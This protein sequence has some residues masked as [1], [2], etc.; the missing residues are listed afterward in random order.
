MDVPE[1]TIEFNRTWIEEL[2]TLEKAL[3]VYHKDKFLAVKKELLGP[4]FD[5]E[6]QTKIWQ[7]Y[8][9]LFAKAVLGKFEKGDIERLER[10]RRL[11][12]HSETLYSLTGGEKFHFP[13]NL[14]RNNAGQI[15]R[16]TFDFFDNEITKRWFN[17][18]YDIL[19]GREDV[20]VCSDESCSN[21]FIRKRR[22]DKK[23]CSDICRI[24]AWRSK[25]RKKNL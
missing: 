17:H 8:H 12:G 23:F 13:T 6:T 11:E 25:R 1:F 16:V 15:V 3:E 4:E 2:T 9:D 20:R 19:V 18:V 7:D 21:F 24:R 10:Y 22:Q 14:T 5:E